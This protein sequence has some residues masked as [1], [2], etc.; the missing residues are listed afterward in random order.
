MKHTSIEPCHADVCFKL[1]YCIMLPTMPLPPTLGTYGT[2]LLTTT[3]VILNQ[4]FGFW[5]LFDSSGQS[6]LTDAPHRNP[7]APQTPKHPEEEQDP[8][9]FSQP[10]SEGS[11]EEHTLGGS[12]GEGLGGGLR[13][14]GEDGVGLGKFAGGVAGGE[15][16]RRI[17]GGGEVK[18]VGGNF[19]N[20]AKALGAL[21]P[22]CTL[23][24]LNI[25]RV[26]GE[27]IQPL[28]NRTNIA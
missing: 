28:L 9:D 8:Q 4:A 5:K 14:G 20:W 11:C 24:A 2:P 17:L 27:K 1:E 23:I 18:G 13:D 7:I 22:P 15:G 21:K 12:G 3:P 16:G 10:K 19:T 25:I 26:E 6:Q